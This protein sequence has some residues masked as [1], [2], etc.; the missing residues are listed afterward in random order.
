MGFWNKLKQGITQLTGG[1]G[2][3]QLVVQ[4]P[5]VKRG[6]SLNVQITL[7][8][9]AQLSGKSVQLQV[10]ALETIKYKVPAQST[11]APAANAQGSSL[12]TEMKDETSSNQ[13]YQNAVLVDAGPVN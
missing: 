7:N 2:N 6:E 13:I 8:A 4:N 12:T 9:T 10:M 11:T 5:K 1:G 3:M